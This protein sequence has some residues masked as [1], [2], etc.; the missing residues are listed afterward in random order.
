MTRRSLLAGTVAALFASA[1]CRPGI[2]SGGVV[3]CAPGDVTAC[4]SG[5]VCL[6]DGVCHR[7]CD[8]PSD[9]P[10]GTACTSGGACVTPTG[11]PPV[12]ADVDGDG[13]ANGAQGH[14]A[15]FTGGGLVVTGSAL[16]DVS[17]SLL[18][19][20]TGLPSFTALGV[21]PGATP[22]RLE[23]DLPAEMPP[24]TYT[25]RVANQHGMSQVTT[26]LLKGEPGVCSPDQCGGGGAF[27]T[28]VAR[29]VNAANGPDTSVT[30]DGN[31]LVTA[32]HDGVWL[33]AIDRATGAARTG[34][35][36]GTTYDVSGPTD[37]Q[38]LLTVLAGLDATSVAVVVTRGDV[39]AAMGWDVRAD[40]HTLGA[41]LMDLGAS[42]LVFELGRG[43]ALALVGTAGSGAGNGVFAISDTGTAEATALLVAGR[44][45]GEHTA[46]P[47]GRTVDTAELRDHSVT[48]AKLA[49]GAVT[50]AAMAAGAVGGNALAAGGVPG[51]AIASGAVSTT[52]LADGA[53]TGANVALA[54]LTSDNLASDAVTATKLAAGAVTETKLAL[55]AVSG[56]VIVA[57]AVGV[58][59]LADG[60]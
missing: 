55:G 60:A 33:G 27:L 3:P 43:D 23:L 29:A 30:V 31:E 35:S 48:A 4:P 51:W 39:S 32:S 38:A 2:V 26:P 52:Q 18:G 44:L 28:L 15:H 13:G 22:T 14:A 16:V 19:A 59:Q 10:D 17:V 49:S 54:T 37:L 7:L 5:A 36:F 47:L 6:D 1:S 41:A 45:V 25:L 46:S 34:S 53:V 40:G 24:G 21:R 50:K 58:T 8:G 42:S 11:P 56:R 57:G 12:I 20:T 9:C